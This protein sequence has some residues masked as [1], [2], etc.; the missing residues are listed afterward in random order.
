MTST[1]VQNLVH[2]EYGTIEDIG[3]LNTDF[4]QHQA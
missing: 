2:D 3:E 4:N 1:G